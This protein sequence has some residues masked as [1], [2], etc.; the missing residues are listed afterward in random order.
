MLRNGHRHLSISWKWIRK[1]LKS[2]FNLRQDSTPSHGTPR[3]L[4]RVQASRSPI[5]QPALSGVANVA[6][7]ETRHRKNPS[8]LTRFTRRLP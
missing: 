2:K 5:T 4:S 6:E 1:G 7:I 3:V 8:W